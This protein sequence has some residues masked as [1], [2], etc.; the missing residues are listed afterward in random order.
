[1]IQYK[2]IT[3]LM[4]LAAMLCGCQKSQVSQQLDRAEAIMEER[5]D[6]ALAILR[7]VD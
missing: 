6:S 7:E 3:F 4:I 2:V 5:P 1:M